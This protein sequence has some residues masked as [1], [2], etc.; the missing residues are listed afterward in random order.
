MTGQRFGKLLVMSRVPDTTQAKWH[1]VCDCGHVSDVF[2]SNLRRGLTISCGC[3]MRMTAKLHSTTHGYGARRDGKTRREYAS[4]SA[5]KQRCHNPTNR[6]FPD[7]GARGIVMCD[8]WRDSFAAFIADMGPCPDGLM[9]DRVDNDG[10]YAPDN[11]RWVDRGVQNMNRRSCVFVEAFG[12]RQTLT[13]WSRECGIK[14]GRIA[15]RL[16][17]GWTPERALTHP[18]R[19][20]S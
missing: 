12:R 15:K 13:E 11:C 7:Y 18:V 6:Q 14:D 2:G 5:A 10:P 9:L 4:W 16:A 20:F 3:V 1:C 17:A 19:T 8:R